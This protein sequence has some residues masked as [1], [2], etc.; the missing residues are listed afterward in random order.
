MK[1]RTSG[2]LADCATASKPGKY[3]PVI[4]KH[5]AM[6]LFS[7]LASNGNR[8]EVLDS[9]LLAPATERR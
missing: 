9:G 3:P 2:S 7:T 1:K 5:T 4:L 6:W 8:A